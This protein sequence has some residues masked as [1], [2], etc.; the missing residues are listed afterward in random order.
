M[1]SKISIKDTFPPHMLIIPLITNKNIKT[2][3]IIPEATFN[4][5]IKRIYTALKL[6]LKHENTDRVQIMS[7]TRHLLFLLLPGN[8]S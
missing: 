5:S 7:K 8:K 4:L 1:T 6:L 3:T 2:S